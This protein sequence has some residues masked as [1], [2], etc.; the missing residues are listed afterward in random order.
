MARSLMPGYQ[1]LAEKLIILNDRAQ[2][3]LT[4]LYNIRK[5][6]IDPESKPRFLQ[7][8]QLEPAI[9]HVEKKFP[10]INAK[11][12]GGVYGYLAQI[13]GDVQKQLSIYYETFVDILDF[14]DHVS[15]LLT[16]MDACQITLDI[17][18]NYDVTV[19]YLELVTKYV[20]LMIILS[21]VDDRKAMLGLYTAVN[22]LANGVSEPSF[23]RLGQMILDYESPLKKLCEDFVPHNRILSSALLSLQKI[24]SRRNLTADQWRSAQL[25]NLTS[26]PL[27]LS[28]P[29]HTETTACEYLSLETMERWILIGFTLCHTSLNQPV[30]M[31]LWSLALHTSWIMTLF[32][33]EAIQVHYY[34]ISFFE[35]IKGLNKRVNELRDSYAAVVQNSIVFHKDR[36]L[37]LRIALKELNLLF[38]DQPGLLGPKALLALI[39]LSLARDEISWL[40][41]HS[42]HFDP[43]QPSKDKRNRGYDEII[44]RHLP[45]LLFLTEQ[46]RELIRRHGKIIQ[47]YHIQYLGSFDS[48]MLNA[49]MQNI[50]TL[51]EDEN[52]ILSSLC[53]SLSELSRRKNNSD[54][55]CDTADLRD[56]RL[57]WFRVQASASSTARNNFVLHEHKDLVSHLNTVAYHSRLV[58]DL[59]NL[60]EEV[61]DLSICCFYQSFFQ[62]QFS[63]CLEF[64][65]QTRFI[66]AFPLICGHFM[67]AT[68]ELCPEER[69]CLG[70][71]A[72]GMTN[73]FLEEMGKEAKGIIF[74]ICDAQNVLADQLSPKYAAYVLVNQAAQERK[75]KKSKAAPV[76]HTLPFPGHE[77]YRR[78]REDLT[79]YDKC[80]M[81]LTE[82]CYSI[83]Y[84]SS[85]VVWEHIFCPKEYLVQQIESSLGKVF[86]DLINYNPETHGIARPSELLVWIQTYMNTLQTLENYVQVDMSR[87]FNT[88]MLQQTQPTDTYGQKTITQ[89]YTTWYLETM[90]RRVSNG[91]IVFSP[92]QKAFVAINHEGGG[93]VR[94]EDYVNLVELRALAELIGPYGMKYFYETLTWNVA[95][96]IGEL[97]KLVLQ[98]SAVLLDLR[99]SFDKPENMKELSKRLQNADNLLH[100]MILIGMILHFRS[101][102]QEPLIEAVKKH[103]P[104]LYS[105]VEDFMSSTHTGDA[106]MLVNEMLISVGLEPNIDAVLINAIRAQKNEKKENVS[107]EDHQFTCLL[108]VFLAV[109]LPRL[110]RLDEAVFNVALEAHMNNMHCLGKAVN[111]VLGAMF[112]LCDRGDTVDRMR[113]FLA[114]ASSSLLRLAT[115]SDKEAIKNRDS[116]Y[117]LLEYIVKESPFLTQDLFEACFPQALYRT[118]YQAV[119]RTDRHL[120][121]FA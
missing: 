25:L 115:E 121:S 33:D 85:V 119:H 88:V 71:I 93:L 84:S 81:A 7:D 23:P 90:L 34:L 10:A 67:A 103:V 114:L 46:L 51:P 74:D 86:V 102:C 18:A 112:Y 5:A 69:S 29:A 96:Q 60:L 24:Y 118:A 101:L 28:T 47:T 80:H 21:R 64:P 113:E 6:C 4:R 32:R 105:S 95:T 106:M 100:R 62:E 20:C 26:F 110:A 15:E 27:T 75:G 61:S 35:S 37:F 38:S 41:R 16:T 78:S 89:I 54:I 79:T 44:D 2:G 22:E 57:D 12:N 97:K 36:R 70:N 58:D 42:V 9:R 8:K 11:S 31:E 73:F 59:D 87:V 63:L 108:M 49:L 48:G 50:S 14:K 83:N 40:I 13:R 77:S 55:N 94:P 92:L 43:G 52:V 53:H 66:I 76:H 1:K 72:I 91:H 45:E 99:T 107:E 68:H 120:N 117:L 65:S 111:V 30:A 116:T 17:T 3:M 109:S 39:A 19:R 82:L 98:N 104:Y 56:V